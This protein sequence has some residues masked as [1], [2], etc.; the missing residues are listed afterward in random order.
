[1]FEINLERIRAHVTL[2][3][4]AIRNLFYTS[5]NIDFACDAVILAKPDGGQAN[6]TGHRLHPASILYVET[7]RIEIN[8]HLVPAS[9]FFSTSLVTVAAVICEMSM[10]IEVGSRGFMNNAELLLESI[11]NQ[12]SCVR[13]MCVDKHL[14]QCN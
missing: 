11:I 14:P 13:W 4:L 1:M 8:S 3:W 6:I 7:N 10:Q 2:I 9:L 5:L 12:I